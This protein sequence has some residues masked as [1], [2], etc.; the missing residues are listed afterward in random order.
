MSPRSGAVHA[1]SKHVV[2]IGS[3]DADRLWAL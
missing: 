2:S 3:M 1:V